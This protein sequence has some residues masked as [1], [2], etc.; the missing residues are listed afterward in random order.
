MVPTNYPWHPCNGCVWGSDTGIGIYCP[1][2][3]CPGKR[4]IIKEKRV[5]VPAKNKDEEEG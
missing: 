1:F 4:P 3:N 2:T 5:P